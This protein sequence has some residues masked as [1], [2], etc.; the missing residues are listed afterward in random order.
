MSSGSHQSYKIRVGDEFSSFE[1]AQRAVFNLAR[2]EGMSF[3]RRDSRTVKAASKRVKTPINPELKFYHITWA[4]QKGG[5]KDR[6][7]LHS[8]VFSNC[9][10]QIRVSASRD[11]QKLVVV[12]AD[13]GH[14]HLPDEQDEGLQRKQHAVT[15]QTEQLSRA[16]HTEKSPALPEESVDQSSHPNEVEVLES[17]A[18]NGQGFSQSTSRDQNLEGTLADIKNDTESIVEV[19]VDEGRKLSGIYYQ[20]KVMQKHFQL[21]PELLVVDATFTLAC[22]SMIVYVQFAVDGNGESEIVSVFVVNKDAETISAMLDIFKHYNPAWERIRSILTDRSSTHREVYKCHLPGAS[23]QSCPLHTFLAMEREMNPERMKVNTKQRPLCLEQMR[24]VM[25]SSS[26]EEYHENRERLYQTGVEAAISYFN[27]VWDPVREDWVV[28]LN[29]SCLFKRSCTEWLAA[30]HSKLS[31]LSCNSPDLKNFFHDL[32]QHCQSLRLGREKQI[33]KAM[34]NAAAASQPVTVEARYSKV[35][36]PY[37]H[38]LVLKQL[39]RVSQEDGPE[40]ETG[41]GVFSAGAAA[42]AT[43]TTCTCLFARLNRL[44]CRHVFALRAKRG[45]DLFSEEGVAERWCLKHY[46]RKVLQEHA[47][48]LAEP[49]TERKHGFTENL[50]EKLV[51]LTAAPSAAVY[52]ERI[53]TLRKLANLWRQGKHASV[54]ELVEVRL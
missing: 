36:T 42:H 20:D 37:A 44:P 47:E 3:W 25:Y 21:F 53:E 27:R 54:I 16:E 9:T 45:L 34:L 38:R 41:G 32:K 50:V 18:P 22:L 43:A 12:K 35:L 28:G 10:A 8:R 24:K 5:R 40:V 2:A 17:T 7:H 29:E 4:C 46:C 14:N 11:G 31:Q 30:V 1:E 13:L 23:I 33:V 6:A 39:A 51:R 49:S 19:L 52:E 15:Y 48:A 26:V